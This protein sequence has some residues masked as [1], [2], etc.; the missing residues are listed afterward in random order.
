MMMVPTMWRKSCKNNY[1]DELGTERPGFIY[2]QYE[3][4][5]PRSKTGLIKMLVVLPSHQ[6]LFTDYQL[7]HLPRVAEPPRTCLLTHRDNVEP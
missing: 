2:G 6:L 4:H 7:I 5:S 3:V 1:I